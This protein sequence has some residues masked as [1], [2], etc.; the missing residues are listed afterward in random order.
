[1]FAHTAQ[2]L[3]AIT[4]LALL[5]NISKL[6]FY[7]ELVQIGIVFCYAVRINCLLREDLATIE[8]NVNI[9]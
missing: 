9:F 2:M 7:L 3:N 1:L 4:W 5:A 8:E 6:Y